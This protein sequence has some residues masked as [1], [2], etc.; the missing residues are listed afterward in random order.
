M[1]SEEPPGI[2]RLPFG[3]TD[4]EI[5]L[6]DLHV[7]THELMNKLYI[8]ENKRWENAKALS[9][10]GSYSEYFLCSLSQMQSLFGESRDSLS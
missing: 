8:I 7:Q 5:C 1:K 10:T 4:G 6:L 2:P 3:I 9:V